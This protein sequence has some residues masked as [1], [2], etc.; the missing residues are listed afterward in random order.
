MGEVIQALSDIGLKVTRD[1][2][3]EAMQKQA[4]GKLPFSAQ[5]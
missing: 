4:A 1:C 2:M 3:N 5:S